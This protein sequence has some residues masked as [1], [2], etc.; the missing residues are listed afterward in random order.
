MSCSAQDSPPQQ[1]MIQPPNV[2]SAK[3]EK[4]GADRRCSYPFKLR[5]PFQ[6]TSFHSPYCPPPH[7]ITKEEEPLGQQFPVE[8]HAL[9]SEEEQLK[10][11]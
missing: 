7:K 2:S 4:P 10:L 9:K 3:V 1:G 8:S 5:T 11:I 6:F